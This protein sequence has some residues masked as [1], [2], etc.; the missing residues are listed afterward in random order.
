MAGSAGAL[1]C[2]CAAPKCLKT[3]FRSLYESYQS[4]DQLD[5]WVWEI[6]EGLAFDPARDHIE[7]SLGLIVGGNVPCEKRPFLEFFLCLSRACLG[8][9]IV[10]IYKWREKY[11]F[12]TRR[13]NHS[14]PAERQFMSER[15]STLPRR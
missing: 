12:L 9:M 11:V 6:R 13:S 3:R 4:L 1:S 7:G 14:I 10:F 15:R 5:F 2:C 8:K